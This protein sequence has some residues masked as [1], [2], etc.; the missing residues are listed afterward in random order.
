MA[1]NGSAASAGVEIGELGEEIG[2]GGGEVG[3]QRAPDPVWVG[4]DEGFGGVGGIVASS[5]VL[6]V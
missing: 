5:R 4:E 2:V 3:D 1:R 6:G